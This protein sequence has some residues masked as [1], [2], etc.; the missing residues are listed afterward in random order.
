MLM[1]QEAG[2][3]D[4]RQGN[5]RFV[6]GGPPKKLNEDAASNEPV[7]GTVASDKQDRA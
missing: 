5:E 3:E 7:V 2:G 4:I 6:S 1:R